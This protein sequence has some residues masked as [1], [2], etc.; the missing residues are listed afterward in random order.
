MPRGMR[1]NFT[2]EHFDAGCQEG[3]KDIW[4][5]RIAVVRSKS[6]LT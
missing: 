6:P 3:T 4:I 1:L 2:F 5:A